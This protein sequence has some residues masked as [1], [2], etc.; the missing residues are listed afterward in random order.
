VGE[1]G[2]GFG[3]RTVRNTA[4]PSATRA[5]A[6]PAPSAASHQWNPSAEPIGDAEPD[7]LGGGP[8]VAFSDDVPGPT[9]CDS[10]EPL[11]SGGCAIALSG[12]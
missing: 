6:A 5:I 12:A 7:V 1:A 4:P 9:L 8:T 2:T 3:L 10:P 11:G